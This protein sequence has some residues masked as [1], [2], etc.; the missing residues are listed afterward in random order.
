MQTREFQMSGSKSN[1]VELSRGELIYIKDVLMAIK[2]NTPVEE[3]TEE[4]EEAL[5]IIDLRFVFTRSK[6]KINKNSKTTYADICEGRGRGPFKGVT[7]LYADKRI[8][9][10]WL[11]E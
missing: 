6:A 9:D 7:W 3:M 11:Q 5:E 4:L 1:L 2:D 10:E 8:P